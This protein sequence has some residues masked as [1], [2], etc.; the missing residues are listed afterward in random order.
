MYVGLD[1]HKE[2]CQACFVNAKGQIVKEAVFKCDS[3]GIENLVKATHRSKVAMEASS[4][5]IRIYDA[6]CKTC[7]VK[8][9]HPL[10]LKAIAS[11]KIKTDKIDARILA[12]LL[13]AGLIPEAHIPSADQRKGRLLVRQ[14]DCLVKMRTSVKNRIH[15][16]LLTEGVSEPECELFG[17]EGMSFL[18]TAEV[19]EQQRM[20]L[21]SMVSMLDTLNAQI[22]GFDRQIARDGAE[23]N[24]AK[25]L[26]TICGVGWLTA[27]AVSKEIGDIKLAI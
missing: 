26:V 23:D 18:R 6:L 12:Q 17:N 24:Y 7:D 3:K 22:N 13:R 9:A 27:F 11:A 19:S 4:S 2:F 1:V 16:L 15:S 5:S 20:S 8:V 25:I 10:M 21:D 14:R